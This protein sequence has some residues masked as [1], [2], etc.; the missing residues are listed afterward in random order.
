MSVL[1]TA[2]H[3]HDYS[4]FC[5]SQAD[6]LEAVLA[7]DATGVDSVLSSGRVDVDTQLRVRL[8]SLDSEFPYSDLVTYCTPCGGSFVGNVY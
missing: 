3:Y 6:F 8:S 1:L 2:Q 7:R 5:F 4:V